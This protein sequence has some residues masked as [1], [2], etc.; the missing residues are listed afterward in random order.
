LGRRYPEPIVDVAAAARAARETIYGLRR[1]PGFAEERAEVLERHGSRM[2]PRSR[3]GTRGK[4]SSAQ[5]S[6]DL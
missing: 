6:L 4:S 5:L 2:P 1:A 3:A